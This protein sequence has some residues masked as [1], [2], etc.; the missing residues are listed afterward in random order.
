MLQRIPDRQ[1]ALSNDSCSGTCVWKVKRFSGDRRR[2]RFDLSNE[3]AP[4][5][6]ISTACWVDRHFECASLGVRFLL[7]GKTS[8]DSE[9][10]TYVLGHDRKEI[11]DVRRKVIVRIMKCLRLSGVHCAYPLPTGVSVVSTFDVAERRPGESA[12]QEWRPIGHAEVAT[13]L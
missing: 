11:L 2:G 8:L 5:S 12:A 10:F 6:V 13:S 4:T 1:E 9:V 3:N 7:I